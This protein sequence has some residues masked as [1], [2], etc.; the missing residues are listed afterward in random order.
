[1]RAAVLTA[2]WLAV[3]CL[4]GGCSSS[5]CESVCAEANACA[6]N[7]RPADV[8]CTPYCEDVESFQDRAIEAGQADC[9]AQFEAHL[10]C[11]EQ[12]TQSICDKNFSGCAEQAKAWTSC[13]TA[14]CKTEAGA[15]DPNCLRGAPT[16]QPF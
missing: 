10:D 3:M 6:L 13:V 12:N 15:S 9:H 11:W 2:S 8:E 16:L 5:K 14:Y 7:E 1:M 4:A